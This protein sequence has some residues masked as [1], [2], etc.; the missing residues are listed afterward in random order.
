MAYNRRDL[1]GHFIRLKQPAQKMCSHAC[2]RGYRV[3]PSNMPVILPNKLLQRAS[4]DDLRE[5][6][7]RVSRGGSNKEIEA[8]YQILA[9]MDRRD[10]RPAGSASGVIGGSTASPRDLRQDG[11]VADRYTSPGGWTVEVVQLA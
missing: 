1:I 9:V 2:C 3:H 11:P 4:D 8:Q 6:Y 7:Q 10:R 5:H